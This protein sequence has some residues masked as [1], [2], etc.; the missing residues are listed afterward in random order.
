MLVPCGCEHRHGLGCYEVR[1]FVSLHAEKTGRS[2]IFLSFD[3]N[4]D[5]RNS[6]LHFDI[7]VTTLCIN[8]HSLNSIL[9]SIST[10]CTEELFVTMLQDVS[11]RAKNAVLDRMEEVIAISKYSVVFNKIYPSLG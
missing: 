10:I 8:Q 3:V 9:P 1:I 2:I 6:I 11:I 4:T 5:C 7:S